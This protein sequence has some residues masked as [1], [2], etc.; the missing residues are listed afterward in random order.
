M[1]PTHTLLLQDFDAYLKLEKGLS[2]NTRQSYHDDA[3]KLIGFVEAENLPL[4]EVTLSHLHTF[5]ASL[6]DLGIA[7]ATR[8]RIISGVKSF[9]HF[10][11]EEQHIS[12]NPTTLLENPRSSRKLPEILTTDEIDAMISSIDCSTPEGQRNRAILETLYSCGIRV[13]ELT[14]LL[15][16][17]IYADNQYLIV[18][19]KGKKQRLVPM[20]E[21]ALREIRLW[22]EA[23][24]EFTE[25][26]GCGDYLFISRRGTPLT[27]VMIFYIV[28]KAAE[29]AGVRKTISP[30]TM[31]HSFASHLLEGGANLR[32]IQQM[33]G[34]ESIAT[35]EIYL[36][37]DRSALRREI[38]T[39]HPR[40]QKSTKNRD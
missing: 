20:S 6:L 29:A 21:T 40:N 17:R 23:R 31:R 2:D 5:V 32:A 37:I 35:T 3:C 13:S 38:L 39:H 30:H 16:S 34:H 12:V 4:K 33:L 18:E 14:G 8:S 11:M 36:H 10:L 27:R 24:A 7:V 26:P 1:T 15:I 25:K 9:F 22:L 28:R 19:G